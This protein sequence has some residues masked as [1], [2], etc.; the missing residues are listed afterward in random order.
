MLD[1]P[2]LRLDPDL[3]L[4]GYARPGDAGIDLMARSARVLA[5]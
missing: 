4:P 3:P 5:P 2:I 1:V